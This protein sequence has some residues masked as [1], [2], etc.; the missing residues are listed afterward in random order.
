MRVGI[1]EESRITIAR[2]QS[3]LHFE[4][5]DRVKLLPYNDFDDVVQMC[6]KLIFDT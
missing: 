3:G 5:R 2:F 6:T 1:G 4:I